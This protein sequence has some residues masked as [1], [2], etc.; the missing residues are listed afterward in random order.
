VIDIPPDVQIRSTL[1]S[2]SVFYYTEDS[3]VGDDPHYFVVLNQDPAND[4]QLVLLNATSKVDKARRRTA[5]NP[6]VLVVVTRGQCQDLRED[7]AF[8]GDNA[9]VRTVD[10]LVEK[11]LRQDV[12]RIHGYMPNGVVHQLKAAVLAS[13]EI[14]GDVKKLID[15]NWV[16]PS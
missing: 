11:A 9:I 1:R 16:E 6:A 12:M 13:R 7:S 3:F 14:T 2:G 15:P 5:G 8:I 4:D 10:Q